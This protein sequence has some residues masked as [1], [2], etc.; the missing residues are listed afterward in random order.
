MPNPQID[1]WQGEIAELEVDAIIVPANE[2]L[3][4]T[5]RTG[6]ALKRR[7]G[8][9]VEREAVA[10]GPVPAGSVVVTSAGELAATWLL[11][12]V[13]VG[14]DLQAD[15]KQFA[16]ALDAALTR[17]EELGARRVAMAPLGVERG[18]FLAADAATLTIDALFAHPELDAVIAVV[19]PDDAAAFSAALDAAR[20]GAR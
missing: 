3:F 19:S 5:G 4:M 8:A 6:S 11:H 16:R 10:Q 12:T 20:A 14:H 1:V 18:V 7:A 17:A 9:E 15:A 13:A 2:S